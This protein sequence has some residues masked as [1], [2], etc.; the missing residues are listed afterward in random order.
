MLS[1]SLG[2]LIGATDAVSEEDLVSLRDRF[3]FRPTLFVGLGG[4]GCQAVSKIKSLYS[5]LL[6]P[7]LAAGLKGKDPEEIDGRYGFLAFD[8]DNTSIPTGLRPNRDF[9]HI[10]VGDLGG[11][12]QGAGRSPD[13]D[14][15]ILKG[16]P[17]TSLTAGCAGKR[18]LGRIAFVYNVSDVSKALDSKLAAIQQHAA[19]ADTVSANPVVFVFGSFSGGTGSGGLLDLSFLLR[20]KL[21]NVISPKIL[22]MIAVLDG[23]PQMIPLVKQS[24]LANTFGGL[25][26]LDAFMSGNTPGLPF[27]ERIRYTGGHL[28]WMVHPYDECFLLSSTREEGAQN[29]P[30]QAHVTSFMARF[31]FMISAYTFPPTQDGA[32][33]DTPDYHGLMINHAHLLTHEVKGV[34]TSYL[35]PGLAQVHFPTEE[36]ADAYVLGAARRYLAYL[37]SDGRGDV[38]VEAARRLRDEAGFSASS[39]KTIFLQYLN[40]SGD[41][42]LKVRTY[43]DSLLDLLKPESR[44]ENASEIIKYGEYTLSARQAQ[45]DEALSA[46]VE[47][48]LAKLRESLTVRVHGLMGQSEGLMSATRAFLD[49]MSGWLTQELGTVA[50]ERRQLLEPQRLDLEEQW[51]RVAPLVKDVVTDEGYIDRFQ[52]RWKVESVAGVYAELLN[53]G[54]GLAHNASRIDATSKVLSTLLEH[55]SAI[56]NRIHELVDLDFHAAEGR[57]RIW[58]NEANAVLLHQEH[59]ADSS[60]DEICSVSLLRQQ[61]RDKFAEHLGSKP[62]LVHQ[63][64]IASGLHPKD[65]LD[66][67]RDDGREGSA[68][69]EQIVGWIDSVRFRSL[70][71][72]TPQ[73]IL[74]EGSAAEGVDPIRV[75][76]TVVNKTLQPQMR[77]AN[78]R[79]RLEVDT[80]N[81]YFSGGID[82][83]MRDRLAEKDALD[84]ARIK[85]AENQESHRINFFSVT[86]P[87]A[88]A[89][90]DLLPTVFE[91]AYDR[92]RQDIENSSASRQHKENRLREYHCFPGS[93]NWQSPTRLREG[94]DE[95]LEAFARALAVSFMLEISETD[96]ERMR[97]VRRAKDLRYGVFQVG[98]S[99]FWVWPFFAP[100]PMGA[101]D[102]VEEMWLQYEEKGKPQKLGSNVHDAYLRFCKDSSARTSVRLWLEWFN[103]SWNMLYKAGREIGERKMLALQEFETRKGRTVVAHEVET[104]DAMIEAVKNWDF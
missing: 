22:G 95:E 30:T 43:N 44:Y 25:K 28:G 35:V 59:G 96:V 26:E 65:L 8:S 41:E 90:C 27:N 5:R 20:E 80:E 29:L 54:E 94:V 39:L 104:W 50:E 98:S 88:L 34:R 77:L 75:L 17:A 40:D 53:A 9:Y 32:P 68:L 86:L 52:D 21:R 49:E 24:T 67:K 97:K 10:G 60:V 14:S 63:A 89:G 15:W 45:L 99:H 56:D 46:K 72:W 84:P 103:E 6:Q 91:P 42:T 85:L 1:D 31:A 71:S 51:R 102:G 16:Y 12:Y 57:L 66:R 2:R 38:G 7:R 92:W 83:E 19:R 37:R 76:S 64:L 47:E 81:L 4:T 62:A 101:P 61:W 3:P 82:E 87:V 79:N 11:F 78:M 58:E 70:R 73:K 13:F 55:V 18:N 23:L 100:Q 36:V 93:W 48:L 33:Q 69:A 74:M